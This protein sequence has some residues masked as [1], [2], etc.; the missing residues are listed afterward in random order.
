[1]KSECDTLDTTITPLGLLLVEKAK[2]AIDKIDISVNEVTIVDEL[3]EKFARFR[4]N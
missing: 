2:E 3:R 4:Q 1:L